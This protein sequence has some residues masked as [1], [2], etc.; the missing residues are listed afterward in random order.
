MWYEKKGILIDVIFQW[1]SICIWCLIRSQLNI[2]SYSFQKHLSDFSRKNKQ[3]GPLPL[4]T[5]FCM[6][7]MIVVQ[8]SKTEDKKKSVAL[9][10]WFPFL[11]Q[12]SLFFFVFIGRKKRKPR[13]NLHSMRFYSSSTSRHRKS[14]SEIF[15]QAISKGKK[16]IIWDFKHW[17]N[18]THIVKLYWN[19]ELC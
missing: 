19:V 14:K 5:W 1:P 2:D 13:S 3:K 12:V 15:R 10:L 7:V 8:H 9:L 17:C 11:E 16:N 6:S 18:E 4:L